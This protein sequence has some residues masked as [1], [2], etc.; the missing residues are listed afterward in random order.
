MSNRFVC[1]YFVLH[2]FSVFCVASRQIPIGNFHLNKRHSIYLD[3]PNNE[4]LRQERPPH[5]RTGQIHPAMYERGRAIPETPTVPIVTEKPQ[6][7]RDP[8]QYVEGR[9]SGINAI[10]QILCNLFK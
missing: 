3:V 8:P 6:R 7:A 4:G 9:V 5:L 10:M 2:M 1:Q